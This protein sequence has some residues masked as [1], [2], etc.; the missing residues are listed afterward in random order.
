[1]KK[2]LLYY[3][4]KIPIIKKLNEI[5]WA[6][7]FHDSIKQYSFLNNLSLNIGRFYA[8]YT[9]LYL[10]HRIIEISKPKEILELGLGESTKFISTI[11]EHNNK[12]CNHLIIE[13]N[14]EWM[15][16]FLKDFK[17]NENSEIKIL[18]LKQTK[19]LNKFKSNNYEDFSKINKK[20]QLIII[21]GPFGTK[22]YSR[23]DVLQNLEN[24]ISFENFIIV[25][26]DTERKGEY[27]T[28]KAIIKKLKKEKID[29]NYCQYYGNKTISL[30]FSSN[31]Y[32]LKSL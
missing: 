11:L 14:S 9:L 30:V 13:H 19:Y 8:N 22:N 10:L 32:Y 26:D 3:Y 18:N 12:D 7:V 29:F 16:I 21:D 5:I 24:L 20:F 2:Y 17:L 4:Q 28:Y 15:N 6:N 25:L 31:Y 27:Q 1:M 23:N